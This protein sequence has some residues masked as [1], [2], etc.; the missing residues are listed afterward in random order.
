MTITLTADPETAPHPAARVAAAGT[1]VLA[2]ALRLAS[3][4]AQ[5]T[6]PANQDALAWAAANPGLAS[7]TKLLDLLALP[8]IFGAALVY[9]LLSRQSSPAFPTPAE[10]SSGAAW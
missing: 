7:L 10:V 2:D 9:V 5:P 4:L 1:L 8:F 6:L 3:H